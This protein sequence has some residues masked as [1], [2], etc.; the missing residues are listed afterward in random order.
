[1]A[2]TLT[3]ANLPRVR[4]YADALALYEKNERFH[5]GYNYRGITN[6]RDTSKRIHKCGDVIRFI[7]YQ[8]A[9][10]EWHPDKVVTRVWNSPSSCTFSGAFLPPGIDAVSVHGLMFLWTSAG[11]F[12][13]KGIALDFTFDKAKNLWSPVAEQCATFT[14][15]V[16]N[17]KRA[18]W[19]RKQLKE[20]ITWRD[21][22]DRL[23]GER[24]FEIG[25]YNGGFRYL[26]QLLNGDPIDSKEE[27]RQYTVLREK[28][29]FRN[30]YILAGA[31]EKVELPFGSAPK[32]SPYDHNLAWGYLRHP[33]Y[34]VKD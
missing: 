34:T 4:S 1:M 24:E 29:L 17:H 25:N 21:V 18:A 11:Y 14:A 32:K 27:L 20:W 26:I 3:G 9:L 19:V 31:V 6:K 30:A 5:T 2:F 23:H 28:D 15:C 12:A 16:L 7:Y 13:P 33:E 10:V 8:T 22:M